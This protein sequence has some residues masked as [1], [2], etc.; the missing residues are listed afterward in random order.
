MNGNNI[1]YF[2]S[3]A[4]DHIP[5]KIRK[6]LGD[7]NV[8]T[9]IDR[10]KACNPI[11]CKYF[12]IGFIDFMLKGKGLLDYANILSP[13]DYDQNDEIMLKYFQ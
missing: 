8:K 9:N 3:F 5:K 7:K 6:L 11:M 12:C 10:I 2:N 1:V 13:N 4:V